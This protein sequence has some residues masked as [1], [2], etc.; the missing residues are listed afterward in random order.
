MAE[1]AKSSPI[2]AEAMARRARLVATLAAMELSAPS[3]E[4]AP[5]QALRRLLEAPPGPDP[6]PCLAAVCSADLAEEGLELLRH[7]RRSGADPEQVKVLGALLEGPGSRAME[8][9]LAGWQL[10]SRRTTVRLAYAKTTEALGFDDGDL[11]AIFLRAFRLE[12]FPL[13]LDL[14][15]RPRPMLRLEL[16]LPAGAG[17]QVEW[18]EV[19]LR[20]DPPGAVAEHRARLNTRLPAGLQITQ[21]MLIPAFASPLGELAEA[22]TWTWVCPAPRLA[23]AHVASEGFLAA[24]TFAWARDGGPG[25]RKPARQLDLRPLVLGLRWEGATLHTTTR[26]GLQDG[27]NPLKLHAAILGLEPGELRGLLRTDIQFRADPRLAQSERYE[28]K[29]K[30]MYEDAVL[31]SGGSNITLVDDDDD[32]PILLG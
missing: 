25:S 20:T 30:N 14:G 12:G 6:G 26:T 4:P 7:E 28:A 23:Q 32:E 18:L 27:L 16:P 9:R 31:L 24:A 1:F 19:V 5:L 17:G 21:W 8:R 13:A 2:P 11:H 3:L 29:L 22:S 10:D 15:K